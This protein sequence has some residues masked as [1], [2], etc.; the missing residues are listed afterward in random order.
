MS[1]TPPPPPGPGDSAPYGGQHQSGGPTP[2]PPPQGPG[3]PWNGPGG[4][5]G[6]G[7]YGGPPQGYGQPPAPQGDNPVATF[8]AALFDLSFSKFVTLTFVK[9]L[10]VLGI[11]AV[12]IAWLF[13]LITGFSADALLGVLV[14]IL[15]P[16]VALLYIVLIRVSLEISVAVIR[17]AINTG[18]LADSGNEN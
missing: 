14:L 7:G 9:I 18:K 10:Y 16:I 4:P 2:P 15:G 5:G 13:F 3:A 12:A 8:F 1:S 6:P 17:V 11:A